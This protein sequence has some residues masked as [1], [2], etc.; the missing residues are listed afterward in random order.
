M[1]R[2]GSFKPLAAAL[3][4]LALLLGTALA[5]RAAMPEVKVSPELVEIGAFFQGAEITVSGEIP[6]GA[7]AV[8]EVLGPEATEHLMRKGRRGGLWMNVGEVEVR[9]APSLYLARATDPR[10]LSHQAPEARFGFA[11]LKRR[12]AAAGGTAT[13]A[14]LDEFLKL[15]ESEDL[16]RILPQPLEAAAAGGSRL[17]KAAFRLPTQVKP[18]TYRVCL[19]VLEAGRVSGRKC[20]GLKVAMVGFPALSAALAYE[21]GVLYGILAVIIAMV[22]GL[23]MGYLFRGGGGH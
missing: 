7:E 22:T 3:L 20:A 16:Y 4:S 11:A 2:R 18:G 10:L 19:S 6:P 12:L 17:V 21:H 13:P 14:E 15:K 1:R 8:V 5:A 23:V 9:T